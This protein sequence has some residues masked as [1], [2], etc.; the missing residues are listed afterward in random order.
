[1]QVYHSKGFIMGAARTAAE[2]VVGL[3]ER[4][5]GANSITDVLCG[6]AGSEHVLFYSTSKRLTG[7]KDRGTDMPA[8]GIG[9]RA[10]VS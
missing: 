7:Q 5:L 6:W 4:P 9:I 3:T 2:K 1:V 10:N 8:P